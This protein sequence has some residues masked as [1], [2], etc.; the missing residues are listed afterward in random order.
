M[1][2]NSAEVYVLWRQ[3]L[4]YSYCWWTKNFSEKDCYTA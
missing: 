4:T 1:M 2:K 3:I